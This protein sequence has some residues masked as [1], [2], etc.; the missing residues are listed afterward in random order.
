M[1]LFD[2]LVRLACGPLH[3]RRNAFLD[4]CALDA[5]LKSSLRVQP[6]QSSTVFGSKMPDV[7]K[8][9]KEDLTRRSL[10]NAAVSHSLLGSRRKKAGP[11]SEEVKLV[12]N[13]SDS[14]QRQVVSKPAVLP[15]TSNFSWFFFLS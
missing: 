10:Q 4:K 9:Y 7:A 12:V 8:T 5:S 2:V 3:A 15:Q 13:I 14:G 11:E 6:L 1:H